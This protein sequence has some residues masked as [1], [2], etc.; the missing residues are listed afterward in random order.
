[1]GFPGIVPIGQT[2]LSQKLVKIL[3]A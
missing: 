2:L 1:V 3:L